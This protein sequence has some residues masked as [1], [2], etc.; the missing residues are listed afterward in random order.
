[1]TASQ[2]GTIASRYSRF[3]PRQRAID[4]INKKWNLGMEVKYYDG[5]PTTEKEMFNIIESE[6]EEND[7]SLSNNTM[8]AN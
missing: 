1:M 8:V 2:G 5:I 6:V 7:I 3:N 4:E